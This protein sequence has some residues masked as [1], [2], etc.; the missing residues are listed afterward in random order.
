MNLTRPKRNSGTLIAAALL[1]FGGGYRADA[2][3]LADLRHELQKMRAS[4]PLTATARLDLDQV[5]RAGGSPMAEKGSI[6]FGISDTPEGLEIRF[7]RTLTQRVR[8]EEEA[9]RRNPNLTT[10]IHNSINSV[11]GTEVA[12]C[13]DFASLLLRETENARLIEARSGSV[14]GKPARLLLLAIPA[15]LSSFQKKHVKSLEVKMSVWVREDGLP[16][17]VDRSSQLKASFFLVGV[18]NVH[19][20]SWRL[21]KIGDRL[22][23]RRH[24]E[25]TAASGLGQNFSR[26]TTLT[27]TPR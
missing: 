8:N 10:P 24:E 2:D 7:P 4:S 18:D 11:Q 9:H 22:L 13:L 15:R 1:L 25:E 6:E 27:I 12:D 21:I 14:D 3:A 23:A 16:V 19:K 20:E 17:A 26:K 5:T